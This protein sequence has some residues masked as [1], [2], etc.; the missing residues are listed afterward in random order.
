LQTERPD[1]ASQSGQLS[2][3]G[4]NR[5]RP[6]Q[7][8]A[9]HS[10]LGREEREPVCSY[11]FALLSARRQTGPAEARGNCVAQAQS[12]AAACCLLPS[13]LADARGAPASCKELGA[14]NTPTL[15]LPFPAHPPSLS[16]DALTTETPLLGCPLARLCK[17]RPSKSQ[18]PSF[19]TYANPDSTLDVHSLAQASTRLS[20]RSV[21]ALQVILVHMP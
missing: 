9:E 13:L 10:S 17:N 7:S 5:D 11:A 2:L 14:P 4:R 3:G 6:Q 8:T 19:Q 1:D 20:R 21:S 12:L 15:F 16:R 18:G